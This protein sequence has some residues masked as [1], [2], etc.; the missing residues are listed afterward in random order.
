MEQIKETALKNTE[1]EFLIQQFKDG[2]MDAFDA[3]YRRHLPIVYNWV[4]FLI[5][6]DDVEDVTQ[7]VFIAVYKSL[8]RFR[9]QSQ[10]RTW[11]RT[12]A[13]RKIAEYYRLRS[14]KKEPPQTTP[15]DTI[16]QSEGSSS[17]RMEDHIALQKALL[18]LPENYRE[19]ILMRFLE[20]L[21]FN[22][23]AE[24][25]GHHLEAI[26]SLYRRACVALRELLDRYL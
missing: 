24:I 22:E 21:Q 26:K 11:L 15:L 25:K 9:G 17:K 6:L 3:L 5:P 23:I 7:E 20:D 13:N 10:F 2:N 16:S 18:E 8:S 4:R 14:R 19:V 12:L 1:D